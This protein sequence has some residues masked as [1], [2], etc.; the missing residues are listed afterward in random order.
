MMASL[1][2]R[3]IVFSDADKKAVEQYLIINHE[4][5]VTIVGSDDNLRLVEDGA[6]G[7]V[8]QLQ[9]QATGEELGS[10]ELIDKEDGLQALSVKA[11]EGFEEMWHRTSAS[12]GTPKIIQRK[13]GGIDRRWTREDQLGSPKAAASGRMKNNPDP[14]GLAEAAGEDEDE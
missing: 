8:F 2:G 4:G 10:A 3:W 12:D 7:R 5:G 11:K 9:D 13:C 14:F 1:E 6:G